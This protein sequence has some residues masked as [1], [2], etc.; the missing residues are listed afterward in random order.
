[1]LLLKLQLDNGDRVAQLEGLGNC[2][3]AGQR[4]QQLAS[5]QDEARC[6]AQV[7]GPYEETRGGEAWQPRARRWI[8]RL[9]ARRWLL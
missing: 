6:A 5:G 1:M 4:Q 9:H 3:A 8:A 7:G 2:L